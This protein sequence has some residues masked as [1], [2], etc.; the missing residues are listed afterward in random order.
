MAED[1]PGRISAVTAGNGFVALSVKRAEQYRAIMAF[2]LRTG[3][4]SPAPFKSLNFALKEGDQAEN[5]RSNQAVF[6]E[7][8]GIDAGR[9]ATCRQVHGDNIEI[10]E[11]VPEVLSQADAIVTAI[12]GIYPAVKTADC[13]PI[14]LL[15]PVHRVS[16]AIHAGWRGTVLRISRKV[17][18]TMKSYFGTNPADLLA[19]LGPAIGPCCYEVDEVVLNPFR[20][21][22]PQAEQFIVKAESEGKCRPSLRLDLVGANRFELIQEGVPP[23]SI[24]SAQLCTFCNPSLFF[25]YRRDGA[26]SGRHVAVTGFMS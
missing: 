14:L 13:L 23:G 7:R 2:S 10:V 26:C 4:N 15:D 9:I 18:R 25:S 1:F 21:N 8:L 22:V 19:G 20:Q 12:P 16:A 5:V 6:A 3:G 24:H 11:T 17:L